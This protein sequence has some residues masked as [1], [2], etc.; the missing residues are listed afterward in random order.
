MSTVKK[1][2]TQKIKEYSKSIF[3]GAI[4]IFLFNLEAIRT[5]KSFYIMTGVFF[6]MVLTCVVV[7]VPYS[8]GVGLFFIAYLILPSLIILGWTG[9]NMSDS[10]LM[11]NIKGGGIRNLTFFFGQYITIFIVGNILSL[12]FWPIVIIM[13]KSRLF[14][15]IWSD[16]SK[17]LSDGTINYIDPLRNLTWILIIYAAQV[18]IAISF[19]TYLIIQIWINSAKT[20]Y[21]FVI[22]IVILSIIFGGVI[23]DYYYIPPGYGG[24]IKIG[25]RQSI[26]DNVHIEG[27]VI[28]VDSVDAYNQAVSNWWGKNT[29]KPAKGIFPDW[30][31]LPSLLFPFYGIGQFST[32][33]IGVNS[34]WQASTS[35]LTLIVT[36]DPSITIDS[37]NAIPGN[38]HFWSWFAINPLQNEGWKWWLVL[39]Q[40]FFT[41]WAY[42]TF[43]AVSVVAKELL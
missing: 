2:N 14:V 39:L 19:A 11:K 38:I 33:A 7:F 36:G 22:S 9:Y 30:M 4:N 31:F 8:W 29:M 37:L 34:T 25:F 21:M 16:K 5:K 15:A 18:Y 23:N 40:P 10:T 1:V 35:D 13:G 3:R 27:N 12:V 6:A 24:N 42:L 28:T 41:F 26:G 32:S 20:Y 17:Q 43:A